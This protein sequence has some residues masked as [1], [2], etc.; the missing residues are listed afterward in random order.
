MK[1]YMLWT[2][3]A[4]QSTIFLLS[5]LMKVHPIPHVIFE[6]TRSGFIQILHHCSVSWK[7]TP[8]LYFLLF[9]F[10]LCTANPDISSSSK[11]IN[12]TA[13]VV[14]LFLMTMQ[15]RIGSWNKSYIMSLPRLSS[16]YWLIH[17]KPQI[18]FVRPTQI[19]QV[20][21]KISTIRPVLSFCFLWLC[22]RELARE[23]K[24]ISCRCPDWALYTDSFTLNPKSNLRLLLIAWVWNNS[25]LICVLRKVIWRCSDLL[26][27]YSFLR[28]QNTFCSLLL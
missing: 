1:H 12:N 22:R 15:A 25:Y 19:F 13:R 16:I 17:V 26:V 11:N 24:V 2:K 5:V 14:F 3:R 4:H 8:L 6:T 21:A 23:I 28:S 18:G 10:I 9:W 7:I 20:Q 27:Q